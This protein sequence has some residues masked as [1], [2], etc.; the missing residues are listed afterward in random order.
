MAFVVAAPQIRA[1]SDD[2]ADGLIALI[3]GCW[4]EYSGLILDVDR[5][6]QQLRAIA[7][8]FQARNGQFWVAQ[9][10][11]DIV[12]CVGVAPASD[13][14]GAELHKLYVCREVRRSGLGGRLADCVEQAANK[15]AAAF[16]ELWSDTRFTTAHR[17]YERRGY[18]RLSDTRDLDDLSN[19]TEYHFRKA[20]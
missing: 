20:L 17:F 16:V 6:E 11:Q 5:E 2:D 1:A 13:P 18:V 4:S 8:H 19:S 12:G 15:E 14:A 9:L 3:D 10:G 7:T